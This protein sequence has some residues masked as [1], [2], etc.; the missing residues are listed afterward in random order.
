MKQPRMNK[1]GAFG[2][3][4]I[5]RGIV[6]F[7]GFILIVLLSILLVVTT[8]ETNMVCEDAFF[9]GICYSCPANYT[10]NTTSMLCCNSTAG[11]ATNCAGGNTTNYIE[12]DEAAYNASK[13]LEGAALL[14]PQFGEIIVIV[15]VIVGI[16]ALL[17][18]VGYGIYSRIK[19]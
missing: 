13:D 15:I 8:Q 14:A 9:D 12:A 5:N 11:S 10:I 7:I 18:A 17:A 3:D 4:T 1:K 6:S 19:Q 16:V 2:M